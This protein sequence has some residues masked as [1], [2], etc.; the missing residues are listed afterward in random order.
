MNIAVLLKQVPDTTAKIT[1]TDGKVDENA[2]SKWSMSPYDEYALESAL[3]LA[4]ANSG[5]LTAITAGPE[6][7]NRMLTDAAAVGADNLVRIDVAN[8]SALDSTQVQSLLAAAVQN[9][10]ADVV[11]CGK[12]AA[13]T[14]AG[15][16][17]P[18]VAEL[19]DAACVTLVSEVS[20][21]GDGFSALRPSSSGSER[22]A[23]SAPCI[24][25]FDK[26]TTEMRR[27]NVRGIMMAKKKQI[28]VI[29]AADL[30]VDL[31]T[32]SV[33][34]SGHTPP[35][36]KAAGQKFEGAESVSLVVG[37]LREEANVI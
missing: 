34:I 4:S 25:A 2:I 17:G 29:S 27:P 36:Q 1:V 13:D 22:I 31:G 14:N 37:K 23:V 11:F 21:D 24:F 10:N 5:S 12:Q 18:G 16:T 28:E 3:Q 15:S 35:A 6:R 26:G 20:V 30:G 7:C 33:S 19:M 8:L 9:I 32:A